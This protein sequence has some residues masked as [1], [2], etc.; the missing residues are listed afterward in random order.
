VAGAGLVASP[1]GDLE[2]SA[3]WAGPLA[4]VSGGLALA[5]ALR[6]GI[7]P[8]VSLRV[9]QP[10]GARELAAPV[11]LEPAAVVTPIVAGAVVALGA[12]VTWAGWRR[13]A[14]R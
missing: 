5:W 11:E 10:G 2:A 3:R 14:R 13:G 6:A 4:L 8:H 1:S 12:T 9:D 7:S